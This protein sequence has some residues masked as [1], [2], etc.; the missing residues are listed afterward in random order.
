M[1]IAPQ[2]KG[3]VA[4]GLQG[5][6]FGR[7]ERPRKISAGAAACLLFAKFCK[8]SSARKSSF[9]LTDTWRSRFKIVTELSAAPLDCG[10]LAEL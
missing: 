2:H 9:S 7:N 1:M 6:L 4:V 5:R 8:Y 3:L 10:Y